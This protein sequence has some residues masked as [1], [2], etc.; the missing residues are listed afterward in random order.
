MSD[1]YYFQRQ[2]YRSQICDVHCKCSQVNRGDRPSLDDVRTCIGKK[3]K[4][5]QTILLALSQAA[6]LEMHYRRIATVATQNNNQLSEN[7]CTA[8]CTIICLKI[9]EKYLELQPVSDEE[10]AGTFI[11]TTL[12]TFF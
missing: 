5:Q 2:I 9:A 4:K 10:L 7:D 12:L 1:R 3:E 11:W 6:V 8:V